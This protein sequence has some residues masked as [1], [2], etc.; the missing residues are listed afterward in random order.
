MKRGTCDLD[1]FTT[2]IMLVSNSLDSA[3][4]LSST[5][6]SLPCLFGLAFSSDLL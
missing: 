1:L 2:T 5:D 6:L 4:A 3:S